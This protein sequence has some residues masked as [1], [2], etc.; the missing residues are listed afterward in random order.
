MRY[1]FIV[2]L[3]FLSSC[4]TQRNLHFVECGVIL[5][6]EMKI[7]IIH[8]AHRYYNKTTVICGT[9]VDSSLNNPL[10]GVNVVVRKYPIGMVTDSCGRFCL[11][12]INYND[13]IS[14][15]NLGYQKKILLASKI[16]DSLNNC[17]GRVITY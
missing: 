11:E 7:S 4:S 10:Q 17:P 15:S 12:G 16:I 8:I 9:V 6:S 3:L 1:S 14:F 2:L 13:S 5:S